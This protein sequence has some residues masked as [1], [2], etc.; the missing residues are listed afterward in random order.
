MVIYQACRPRRSNT[1][2]RLRSKVEFHDTV[3]W[4]E[5]HQLEFCEVLES[6][7]TERP[8]LSQAYIARYNTSQ[9]KLYIIHL[10]YQSYCYETLSRFKK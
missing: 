7:V 5:I 6:H 9:M 4:G 8:G 3:E 10:I 2:Q 1:W